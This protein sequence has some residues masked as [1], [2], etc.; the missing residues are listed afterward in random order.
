MGIVDD[1]AA[2]SAR[3]C[4]SPWRLPLLQR[5]YLVAALSIALAG[6]AAGFVQSNVHPAKIFMGNAGSLFL[7]FV[8]AAVLLKLCANAPTKVPIAA[9]ILAV[10]GLA[11]FNT[12]LVAVSR[13]VHRISPSSRAARTTRATAW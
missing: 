5:R 2:G 11:L 12:S 10:P 6:C 13:L 7:G 4:D 1:W 9:V 3:G 8:L